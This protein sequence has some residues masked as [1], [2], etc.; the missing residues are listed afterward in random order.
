MTLSIT[1]IALG[2]IGLFV[3]GV[4]GIR[5]GASPHCRK[6]GYDL[7]GIESPTTCPECGRDI[8]NAKAVRRGGLRRKP[9]LAGVCLIVLL[10]GGTLLG[11]RA[12]IA[13]GNLPPSARPVWL[14]KIDAKSEEP[15][16]AEAAIDELYKRYIKE[17]LDDET[18][19]SLVDI[20]LDYHGDASYEWAGSSFIDVLVESNENGLMTDAQMER[21]RKGVFAG[22]DLQAWK[23]RYRTRPGETIST[24]SLITDGVARVL[25]GEYVVILGY[26]TE[27]TLDGEPVELVHERADDVE[28]WLVRTD[29]IKWRSDM[30]G[31]GS[32]PSEH[33]REEKTARF[34]F[35]APEEG[36][37]HNYSGMS[38][39][40]LYL[41]DSRRAVHTRSTSRTSSN[42]SPT[43]V[44]E[45]DSTFTVHV[46]EAPSDVLAYVDSTSDVP[47]PDI[48]P[49]WRT[50][51]PGPHWR[52]SVSLTTR[53]GSASTA[54]WRA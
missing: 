36:G 19:A 24:S 15:A 45:I 30:R 17:E 29:T 43:E 46:I 10:T 11:Y 22:L 39:A 13:T 54:R 23:T 8:S 40:E 31:R 48:A 5:A 41:F 20:A 7:S 50:G 14:L 37:L 32:R 52:L 9:V 49:D 2:V 34:E 18:L 27:L 4:R 51:D 25:F 53:T 21:Y 47:A 1:L 26:P 3:F 12:V 42:A 44:R 38:V 16:R 35:T 28:G 6:C 33:A